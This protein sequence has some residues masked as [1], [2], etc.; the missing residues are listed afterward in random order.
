MSKI[1]KQL[2]KHLEREDEGIGDVG[3]KRVDCE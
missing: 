1:I 3:N 2:Q